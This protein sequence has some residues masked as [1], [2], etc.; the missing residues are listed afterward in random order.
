[1]SNS[2]PEVRADKT[3]NFAPRFK[4]DVK[5]RLKTATVRYNDDKDIQE[6]DMLKCKAG[7]EPFA[8]VEV[9]AVELAEVRKAPDLIRRMAERHGADD[10]QDLKDSLNQF[11]DDQIFA[12]TNVKVIVFEVVDRV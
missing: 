9:T 2:K 8:R 3:L 1:M 6:G 5:D 7:G 10:W 12:T 11:Y 4:Y